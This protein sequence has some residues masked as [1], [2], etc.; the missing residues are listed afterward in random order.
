[1]KHSL[2]TVAI[3]AALAMAS[4]GLAAAQAGGF[5]DVPDDA[6]F[7]VP[8]ATLA[9]Q[10]VFAGTLCDD[11]F[12]PG[13]PIDRKTMAVWVVRILEDRDPPPVIQSRFNDVDITGFHAPYIERMVQLGVTQGCGNGSG[14]CPDDP[15]TRAEMAAFLSRAYRLPDGPDPDLDDVPHY[16]WYAADVAKLVAS[17]ITSGCG[18]GT[19]FCPEQDTTRG[20]MATFLYRAENRPESG[21]PP[22]NAW[23]RTEGESSVGPYVE[24]RTSVDQTEV[25]WRPKGLALTVRCTDDLDTGT[26]VLEVRAFGYGKRTWFWDDYG[27]IEYRFGDDRETT[28]NYSDVSEDRN[29]LIVRDKEEQQFLEAMEV[30]TTGELFLSLYDEWPDGTFDYEASGE[31]RVDGY[32]EHVQPLVDG[33]L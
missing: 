2:A 9:E 20:Q 17:G 33:C 31:L 23:E 24:F 21:L 27:V 30:D 32:R 10:G 29:V 1:M 26:P 13:D 5:G 6:Y 25:P 22:A 16:A 14:Y 28:I 12:C 7:A 3:A 19:N 8:V 11:G 18:D 4:A 15:V